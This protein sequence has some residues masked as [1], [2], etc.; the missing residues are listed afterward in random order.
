MEFVLQLKKT[1]LQQ[2]FTIRK[3][4]SPK[5]KDWKA[6][7]VSIILS[8]EAVCHL[9]QNKSDPLLQFAACFW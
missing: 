7:V 8:A 5:F 2:E 3:Q 4:W 9:T 1:L 6:V